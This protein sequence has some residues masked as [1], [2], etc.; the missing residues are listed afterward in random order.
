LY[1][2]DQYLFAEAEGVAVKALGSGD[3]LISGTKKLIESPEIRADPKKY[4]I[5]RQDLCERM[6]LIQNLSRSFAARNLS[7][8]NTP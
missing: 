8:E 7:P 1:V 6:V 2:G 4:C 3:S 5:A